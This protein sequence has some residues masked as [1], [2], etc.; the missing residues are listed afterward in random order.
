MNKKGGAIAESVMVFP[1]VVLSVA[2][3][4][5][6]MAYFYMQLS[7]RVDMHMV[8][9]AESGMVCGNMFYGNIGENDFSVYKKSQQL[10]SEDVVTFRDSG[11]LM[12]REKS[13][14]ARKYL[15]DEVKFVRMAGAAEDAVSGNEK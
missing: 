14:A 3:I 12:S 8:L 11:I 1:L 13:Q 9:R 5:S 7:Q 6:M 2:A 15:I 10:Y 4:I